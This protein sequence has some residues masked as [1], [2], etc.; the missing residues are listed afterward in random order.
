MKS[1]K[2]IYFT[3]LTLGFALL[4]TSCSKEEA[5]TD[6]EEQTLSYDLDAEIKFILPYPTQGMTGDEIINAYT[7]ASTAEQFSYQKNFM[8]LESYFENKVITASNANEMFSQDMSEL[9]K[10]ENYLSESQI[11]VLENEFKTDVDVQLRAN[12]FWK[13]V[14]SIIDPNPILPNETS[15]VVS[16]HTCTTNTVTL[17]EGNFIK[18]DLVGVIDVDKNKFVNFKKT[19]GVDN[20]EA[21]SARLWNMEAGQ[22]LIFS[23]HPDGKSSKDRMVAVMMQ[24]FTGSADLNSFETDVDNSKVR[25]VFQQGS[26]DDGKL[27]GK[28][29]SLRV[30]GN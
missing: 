19:S 26:S 28:V 7:N 13:T 25:A 15:I 3:L 9:L 6:L 27:D 30:L 5:Y 11:S 16:V 17:W 8:I 12:C 24:S 2:L 29:S 14:G 1:F 4:V 20:D 18:Q 21:R 23:D 22:I 10:F